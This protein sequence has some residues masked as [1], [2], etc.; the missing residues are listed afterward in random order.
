MVAVTQHSTFESRYGDP[1]ANPLGQREDEIREAY[2]VVY[3]EWR[4]EESPSKVKDLEDEILAEF[5]TPTGAV[6]M[7]V[8]SVD[9]TTGKLVLLHGFA[10]YIGNPGRSI[11]D[12][13][14]HFCYDGGVQAGYRDL[15]S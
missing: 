9:S 11:P 4:V 5:V 3:A 2:R 6:A 13:R 10:R 14:A 15:I 7:M 1:T 8:S 12:R